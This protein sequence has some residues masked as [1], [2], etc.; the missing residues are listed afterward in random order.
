MD[1]VGRCN[2]PLPEFQPDIVR[3][4]EDEDCAVCGLC[5]K[6]CLQHFQM[7]DG[8]AHGVSTAPVKARKEIPV[9]ISKA[10]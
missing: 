7:L 1:L 6:H 9:Q 3:C 5:T 10:A 2:L 8:I 4:Q